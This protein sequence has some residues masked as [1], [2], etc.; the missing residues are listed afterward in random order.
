MTGVC[1]VRTIWR[2]GVTLQLQTNANELHCPQSVQAVRPGSNVGKKHPGAASRSCRQVNCH[3]EVGHD[4]SDFR[5]PGEHL[6]TRHQNGK[7]STSRLSILFTGASLSRGCLQCRESPF[8][9]CEGQVKA[10]LLGNRSPPLP[11]WTNVPRN[12]PVMPR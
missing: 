8:P 6:V 12:L 3:K 4:L 7:R 9:E 1:R 10:R 5:E 11:G 2:G